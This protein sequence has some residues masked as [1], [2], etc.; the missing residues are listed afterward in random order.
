MTQ[1]VGSDAFRSE[2]RAGR[3]GMG[4]VVGEAVFDRVAAEASAGRGG[5]QRVS[6]CAVSFGEPVR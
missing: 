1:R 2:G 5:E 3:G 6:G 4:E